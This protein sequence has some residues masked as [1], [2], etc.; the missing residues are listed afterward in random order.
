MS[1]PRF[2]AEE[3]LYR[4]RRF[5]QITAS[6]YRNEK[7]IYPAQFLATPYA[8]VPVDFFQTFREPQCVLI[9]LRG[10]CRWICF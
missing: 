2:T 9:C 5:Y 4:A 6:D 7:G 10:Y 3:S 1:L 8:K